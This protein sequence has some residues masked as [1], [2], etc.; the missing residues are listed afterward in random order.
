MPPPVFKSV[1]SYGSPA[2]PSTSPAANSRAPPS[3]RSRALSCC[4]LM[5]QFLMCYQLVHLRV[6]VA[7]GARDSSL[8]TR[9][10][11]IV[12]RCSQFLHQTLV[13]GLAA[14]TPTCRPDRPPPHHSSIGSDGEQLRTRK[15]DGGS[16]CISFGGSP[17]LVGFLLPKIAKQSAP[18]ASSTQTSALYNRRP[19]DR[20]GHIRPGCY[21]APRNLRPLSTLLLFGFSRIPHERPTLTRRAKAC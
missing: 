15:R 17:S 13:G 20:S 21:T 12:P 19:V 14:D 6:Q 10:P 3:N 16:S 18:L 2:R 8:P 1:S 11:A 9:P 7:P 5:L 4:A